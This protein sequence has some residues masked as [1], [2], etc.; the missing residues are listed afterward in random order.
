VPQAVLHAPTTGAVQTAL[1]KMAGHQ[2][3]DP[4]KG[5]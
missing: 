2:I 4:S 5:T 1:A 3:G